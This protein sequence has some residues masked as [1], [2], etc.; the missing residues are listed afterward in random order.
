MIQII[1]NYKTLMI[2]INFQ[3]FIFQKL[4]IINFNKKKKLFEVFIN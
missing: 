1:S 3:Y 4:T 2:K